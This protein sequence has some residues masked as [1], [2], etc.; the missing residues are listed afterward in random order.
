MLAITMLAI[1]ATT[2]T[3]GPKS[4]R[5]STAGVTSADTATSASATDREEARAV[6]IFRRFRSKSYRLCPHQLHAGRVAEHGEPKKASKKR[7][8]RL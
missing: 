3:A 8:S 2:A 7:S 1:A 6:V 4:V 5:A